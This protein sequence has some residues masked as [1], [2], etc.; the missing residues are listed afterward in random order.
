MRGKGPGY[1]GRMTEQPNGER[2]ESVEDLDQTEVSSRMDKN[3]EGQR[4][5]E[6]TPDAAPGT[7]SAEPPKS[8]PHAMPG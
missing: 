4:N 2:L 5:R 6:D 1:D 3:P 7:E 8:P